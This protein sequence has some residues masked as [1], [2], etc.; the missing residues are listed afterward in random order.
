MSTSTHLS[1]VSNGANQGPAQLLI[2]PP[3]QKLSSISLLKRWQLI[4]DFKAW[5]TLSSLAEDGEER[6]I[7]AQNQY[8]NGIRD[9]SAWR[10]ATMESKMNW[11]IIETK[12]KPA[13]NTKTAT[14]TRSPTKKFIQEIQSVIGPEPSDEDI[15]AWDCYFQAFIKEVQRRG[16]NEHWPQLSTAQEFTKRMGGQP[17]PSQTHD[18]TTKQIHSPDA[19]KSTSSNHPKSQIDGNELAKDKNSLAVNVEGGSENA[20]VRRPKKYRSQERWTRNQTTASLEAASYEPKR[21]NATE[22]DHLTP[23]TLKRPTDAPKSQD[24]LQPK[25]KRR[26][27]L[28]NLG[29]QLGPNWEARV[30]EIGHR[31]TRT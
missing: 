2:I 14:N 19:I 1:L 30:N 20:L 29:S 24:K 12:E 28:D 3:L 21:S 31:P 23:V 4:E 13:Q 17:W 18:S 6:G 7:Q 5:L 25:K 16:E 27:E 9:Y 22:S 26:S 10:F 15:V 11:E 8:A